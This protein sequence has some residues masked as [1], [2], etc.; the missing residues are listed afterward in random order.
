[1]KPESEV[2]ANTRQLMIFQIAIGLIVAAGFKLNS[3]EW[4]S[5]S[6]IFG[7]VT[8][9]GLTI[10]LS[11]GVKRAENSALKDPKKS[12]EILYLGAVQRFLLVLFCF[13]VGLAILKLEPLA[14]A[15]SFGLTQFAYVFNMRNMKK[16]FH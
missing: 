7:M 10:L 8:S 3:S 9:I 6:A 16:R 13:I 14:M 12:I 4:Q 2:V 15:L 11:H 1:M 5:V